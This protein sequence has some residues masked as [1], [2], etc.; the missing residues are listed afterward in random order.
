MITRTKVIMHEGNNYHNHRPHDAH[1]GHNDGMI[2]IVITAMLM[3]KHFQYGLHYDC[4]YDLCLIMHLSDDCVMTMLLIH[5]PFDDYNTCE[6]SLPI[7]LRR[8]W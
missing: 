7:R 8:C 1:V 3:A 6:K 2:M 4:F 5:E